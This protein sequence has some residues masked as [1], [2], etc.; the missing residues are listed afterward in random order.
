[1]RISA[2]DC[3]RSYSHPVTARIASARIARCGAI[4]CKQSY[5]SCVNVASNLHRP[6]DPSNKGNLVWESRTVWQ[7]NS[8]PIRKAVAWILW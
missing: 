1:M 6:C 7:H 3:H 8:W 5:N 4:A 2:L